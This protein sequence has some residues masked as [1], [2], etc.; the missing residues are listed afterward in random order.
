MSQLDF[1]RYQP[2]KIQSSH[3]NDP[4]S[5]YLKKSLFKKC[6]PI[7]HSWKFGP[8]NY[9]RWKFNIQQKI[10]NE[11]GPAWQKLKETIT[12]TDKRISPLAIQIQEALWRRINNLKLLFSRKGRDLRFKRGR[13]KC[14]CIRGQIMPTRNNNRRKSICVSWPLSMKQA[15]KFTFTH[16]KSRTQNIIYPPEKTIFGTSSILARGKSRVLPT[17]PLFTLC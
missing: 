2:Q 17:S 8:I 12:F 4:S 11:L 6:I 15:A 13:R 9:Y 14:S 3:L 7:I 1:F 10:L 16:S 5:F